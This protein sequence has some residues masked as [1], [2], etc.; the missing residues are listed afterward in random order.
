MFS[1]TFVKSKRSDIFIFLMKLIT[2][3]GYMLAFSNAA[4]GIICWG[5]HMT[6]LSSAHSYI[7]DPYNWL[8]FFTRVL[9]IPQMASY[10]GNSGSICCQNDL[11]VS[12]ALLIY[13]LL[14]CLFGSLSPVPP[15]P[16]S[17]LP[18]T[19]ISSQL[20]KAAD[21]PPWVWRDLSSVSA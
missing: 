10:S 13:T 18:S 7:L 2:K 16:S 15:P 11:S 3:V 8:G 12:L 6:S 19:L 4:I 14:H 1:F 9:V 5:I 21:R 17:H 20:V